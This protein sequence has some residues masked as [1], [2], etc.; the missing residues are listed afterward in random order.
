MDFKDLVANEEFEMD[1]S[2]LG[3]NEKEW[4]IDH[5]DICLS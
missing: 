5:I 4:V 2:Q 1:F 3:E